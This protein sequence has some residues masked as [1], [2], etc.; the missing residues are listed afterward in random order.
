MDRRKSCLIGVG[1]QLGKDRREFKAQP[2]YTYACV[3]IFK[4]PT[5][6]RAFSRQVAESL[7]TA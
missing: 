6:V 4:L 2:G 1:W 7:R 5:S 3:Y